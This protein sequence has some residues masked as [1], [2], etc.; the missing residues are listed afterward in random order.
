MSRE[1]LFRAESHDLGLIVTRAMQR[2]A[3]ANEASFQDDL[4]QFSEGRFMQ[5]LPMQ[6]FRAR[7]FKRI[8]NILQRQQ[9]I[10]PL[11]DG[12]RYSNELANLLLSMNC[13]TYSKTD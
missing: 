4:G 12:L 2:D 9:L 5:V 10:K 3:V 8:D 1:L 13:K 7:L 6:A 11:S